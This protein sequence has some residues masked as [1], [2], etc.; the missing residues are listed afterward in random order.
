MTRLRRLVFSVVLPAGLIAAF[1]GACGSS[2]DSSGVGGP[3]IGPQCGAVDAGDR[4]NYVVDVA[5]QDSQ[6]D[7][8][9]GAP[10]FN[11]LCGS[12][13]LPDDVAA[14][15]GTQPE[16]GV[17]EAGAALDGAADVADANDAGNY[18]PPEAGGADAGEAA[19]P[20][21]ACHVRRAA[22][23]KAHGACELAGS[24]ERDAPCV[25]TAD[26]APGLGCVGEGSAGQCRPFCCEAACDGDAGAY[27][28]NRPLRDDADQ[29]DTPLMVPVCVPADNCNLA[30]PYPCTASNPDDCTCKDPATACIVVGDGITACVAP[31]GSGQAGDSCPCAWGHVCSQAT[32]KCLK[33]CSLTATDSGCGAGKCQATKEMPQGFGVCVGASADGG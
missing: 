6:P 21:Y 5:M 31:P 33:I 8:E 32:Q 1:G 17:P 15:A 26:C 18:A 19:A 10:P 3:C 7:Q 12:Q 11:L 13:C 25:T 29:G 14:C 16:A 2:S 22:S 30:E 27:C 9:A 20:V 28:A 4:D 23:G 24:G